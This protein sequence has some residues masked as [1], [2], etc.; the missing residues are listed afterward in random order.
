MTGTNRVSVFFND[1]F[2]NTGFIPLIAF[3]NC[4]IGFTYRSNQP[5]VQTGRRPD[6]N[7][8]SELEESYLLQEPAGILPPMQSGYIR[9]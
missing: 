7:V 4:L 5:L 6:K 1:Y 9:F 3:L 8:S 2:L